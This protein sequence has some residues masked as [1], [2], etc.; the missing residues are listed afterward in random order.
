MKFLCTI[1]KILNRNKRSK[2]VNATWRQFH[3]LQV[4]HFGSYLKVSLLRFQTTIFCFVFYFIRVKQKWKVMCKTTSRSF[5]SCSN[6]NHISLYAPSKLFFSFLFPK[7]FF[8][9]FQLILV[10]SVCDFAAHYE[11]KLATNLRLAV[12]GEHKIRF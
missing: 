7:I 9:L 4:R 2:V 12:K 6:I 11:L 10:K 1:W 8:F 5:P 3:I